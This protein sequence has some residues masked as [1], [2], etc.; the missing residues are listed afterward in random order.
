M[1]LCYLVIEVDMCMSN[2]RSHYPTIKKPVV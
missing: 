2:L 1:K